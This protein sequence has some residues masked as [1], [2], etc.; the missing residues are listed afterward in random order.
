MS[1]ETITPSE[2][3]PRLL[4]YVVWHPAFERGPKLA[5]SIYAHFSRDPERTNARGLGI[6]VFFRSAAIVQ[7]Q[8]PPP[9]A[10]NAARHTAIIVLVDPKMVIADGWDAY[11]AEL[12]QQV[13]AAPD[14]HRLFPVAFDDTAYQLSPQVAAANF[15]RLQGH[16]PEDGPGFL[17]NRLTNELGR[18]L[19]Q[20]PTLTTVET[21]LKNASPPKMRLFISHAKLD[22]EKTAILLRDYI[23]DNLALDTFFD[24]IDIAAG[25]SFEDEINAG[26]DTATFVVVHTDA[27]ASRVW[28]Q[29]EVIRAKRHLRPLVVIHAIEEG[30]ARSFPYIG[31]VPTIRWRA[32]EPL[33]VEAVIGLV[34]R[35]VL[36]SEYF[37]RHFDDLKKLF[38]VPDTVRALPRAPELLTCLALRAESEK[39]PYFVYPDPPLAKQELDL[40]TE[41]D[42]NLRLI[43]PTLLFVRP[44]QPLALAGQNLEKAAAGWRVGLSIS[45]SADLPARGFGPAHLRDAAA[46]FARFLLAA[47]TT[48]AYGGDLRQGGFTEVLFELLTA[49]R[50]ISGEAVDAIQSYLAWPL[51]LD[52]DDTQRARLKNTARFHPIPPPANLGINA[53]DI[54]SAKQ[55]PP[56]TAENR[57]AWARSLT[58]MREQMNAEI[59]ARLLLGGQARGLGKYPGLAE[60]ALL[61]L[62]GGKPVYLIGAF[63]GCAEAV[64]EALRGNKPAALTLDYQAIEEVPRAAIDLYNSQVPPGG[65]P[66]DYK[67]LVAEFEKI[68]VAGLKNG[69]DAKENE[70]LF[71]TMHLPEMIALVLR[72]LGRLGKPPALAG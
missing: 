47:R 6:P 46:E 42:P 71:T 34:L 23:H 61:A 45:D 62:R 5:E 59:H 54:T 16:K 4:I 40:L 28:C 43:T 48:L 51:H 63:G 1:D 18:L 67:A 58:A 60:E 24:A 8:P 27:Y 10:V 31:N 21:E 3:Q 14:R 56:T 13:G 64:I 65:E 22:G 32:E 72:G 20:R 38:G 36:R 12:W 15:I 49:Y 55:V 50:A 35:E 19:T 25:F 33:R 9:I 17:L 39:V 37:Q 53:A 52:L 29:H 26:I 11:V 69:L 41:L 66:I 44:S 70:R 7:G 2:Y 68:G 57:V 30:E